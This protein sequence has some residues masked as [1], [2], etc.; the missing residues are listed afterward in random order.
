MAVFGGDSIH[1][2]PRGSSYQPAATTFLSGEVPLR[3]TTVFG[4]GP[5]GRYEASIRE[6]NGVAV[7]GELVDF[8]GP[9]HDRFPI[10]VALSTTAPYTELHGGVCCDM[11]DA[12]DRAMGG[13]A[14]VDPPP[15]WPFEL[16]Y[17]SRKLP[18]AARL[19]YAVPRVDLP[20]YGY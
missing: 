16:C 20:Q 2:L 6:E 10:D 4:S 19:R 17:D 8:A 18:R 7:G 15:G 11:A 12:F 3:W 1:L 9:G 14:R 5:Q 13:G